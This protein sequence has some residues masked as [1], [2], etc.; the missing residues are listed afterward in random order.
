MQR[1]SRA[2]VRLGQRPPLVL[3]QERRRRKNGTISASTVAKN[4]VLRCQSRPVA[5]WVAGDEW[6]MVSLRGWDTSFL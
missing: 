4:R 2:L 5:T 1:V 3:N 6:S